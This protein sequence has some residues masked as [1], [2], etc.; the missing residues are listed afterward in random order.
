MARLRYAEVDQDA[1]DVSTLKD[2]RFML[3]WTPPTP[4][5]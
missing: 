2:F 5:P 3:Y 1:P 4:M